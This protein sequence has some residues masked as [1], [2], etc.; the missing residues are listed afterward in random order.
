MQPSCIQEVHWVSGFSYFAEMYFHE[1]SGKN[2]GTSDF[3]DFA[4]SKLA[5]NIYSVYH[6][7]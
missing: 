7:R 2:A 5:R 4:R 3:N 1:N 6:R